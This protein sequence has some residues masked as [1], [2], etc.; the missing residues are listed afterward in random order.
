MRLLTIEWMKLK[1]Y[2]TFRIIGILFFVLLPL[3]IWAFKEMFS[4]EA[5][6]PAMSMLGGSYAFPGVWAA[7]GHWTSWFINFPAM[8]VII[9]ITNEFSFRTGRQNIINGF[10]R[11][12]AFHSKVLVVLALSAV[13]AVYYFIVALICGR[14]ASGSFSSIGKGLEYMGYMALYTLNYLGFALLLGLLV[15]RSGL[16]MGLFILYSL[17]LEQILAALLIKFLHGIGKYLPLQ[18][19]DSL[20][21]FPPL[22]TIT[23]TTVNF[24]AFVAVSLVWC[25]VYYLC[26]RLLYQLKDL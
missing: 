1:D 9:I 22:L 13:T 19:S 5:F 14:I 21:P 25:G 24:P 23:H 2:R 18:S 10:T 12:Q 20:F 7:T 15:R 6:G 8:L 17:F 3:W 16:A 26:G 11:V 4:T